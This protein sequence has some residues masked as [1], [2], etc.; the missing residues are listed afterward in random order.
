MAIRAIG[1]EDKE[2]RFSYARTRVFTFIRTKK[3]TE[4]ME[5]AE[6]K[7]LALN[8]DEE[9]QAELDYQTLQSITQKGNE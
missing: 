1:G 6:L 3:V 4:I 2:S 7:V 5:K 8:G 9:A